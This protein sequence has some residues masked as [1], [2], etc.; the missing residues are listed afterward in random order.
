VELARVEQLGADRKPQAEV[1]DG[2][3]FLARSALPPVELDLRP[4]AE[5]VERVRVRFLTPTELKGGGGVALRPEFGV[6][7]GRIRDRVS[8]LRALYGA[9]P[10]GIDFRG[11]GERAVR[12]RLVGSALRWTETTRR[13]GKTGQVHPF[14]GVTGEAEYEGELAEF[15]PYLEVAQWTGVGRQ[16]VWGKGVLGKGVL[17]A[18]GRTGSP[19]AAGL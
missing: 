10:L 18:C 1:F 13:S 15:V 7:F 14:G 11:M 5:R 3:T 19:S 16:T 4:R 8:T 17:E 9:G 6:L 12:V 2:R